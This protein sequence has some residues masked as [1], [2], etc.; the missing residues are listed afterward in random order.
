MSVQSTSAV[1]GRIEDEFISFVNARPVENVDK[2]RIKEL[3]LDYLKK[4]AG[5]SD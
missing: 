5:Q 4:G 3:G 1:F 2:Q